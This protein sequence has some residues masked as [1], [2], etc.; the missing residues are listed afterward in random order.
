MSFIIFV[1]VFTQR[2]PQEASNIMKNSVSVHR[3]AQLCLTYSVIVPGWDFLRRQIDFTIRM[4]S[5]LFFLFFSLDRL[6]KISM[7]G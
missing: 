2:C 4:R 5:P 3:I 6:R 7:F 1:G